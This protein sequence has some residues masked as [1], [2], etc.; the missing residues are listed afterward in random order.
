[1]C[2]ID[3]K[4]VSNFK[5]I[6]IYLQFYRIIPSCYIIVILRIKKDFRNIPINTLGSE[7]EKVIMREMTCKGY[8]LCIEM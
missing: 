7:W 2:L 8:S 6:L 5:F 4:Y 3:V 1:M